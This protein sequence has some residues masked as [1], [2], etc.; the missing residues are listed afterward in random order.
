MNSLLMDAEKLPFGKIAS[1]EKQG[2]WFKIN[3]A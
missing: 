2:I 3:I 1:M